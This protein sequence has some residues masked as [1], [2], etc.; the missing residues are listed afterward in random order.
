V[1]SEEHNG[2]K[3]QEIIQPQLIS[4]LRDIRLFVGLAQQAS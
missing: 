2:K 1:I 3:H 4:N